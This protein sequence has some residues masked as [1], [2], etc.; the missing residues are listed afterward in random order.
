MAYKVTLIP[1][2]GIGPEV[3]SAAVDVIEATGVHIN[4]E[5]VEAGG[6]AMEKEG[7]PLPAYVIES[8]RKNKIALKG[9]LTT[10]IGY[11]FRSLNVALRKEFDLFANIRPV[12]SF[13]GVESLH[14]DVDLIIVRENTEDLY[15]GQERMIDENRAE[16]IKVITKGAS[17]RIC[18][19]AFYLAENLNRKKVTLV[20]KANILK[21]TDGLFLET[22]RKVAKDHPHIEFEEVIVDAMSMKLVQNPQDYQ[23]I[24]APNL[25]GDI[26]SDLAAGLVGGLGLAP[27]ANI[28]EDIAIFEPVHGSALDIANMN[29]ANPISAILS[30]AMMLKHMGR[31]KE[32]GM[33]EDA[34]EDVLKDKESRTRD[35]GG[36]L[37]TRE[38]TEKIIEKIYSYKQVEGDGYAKEI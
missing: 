11:G 12:R 38:F 27:S 16:S 10:P 33:I 17:E 25:Y 32:A 19:Y 13:D 14:K 9:P 6:Q 28:G 15:I 30:G 21:L 35:L 7:T 24:V 2:D 18:K 8:I 26:L 34:I 4:W 23:V 3:I 22:G 20:H 1:G 31:L 29:M 37:G 5:R 36:I